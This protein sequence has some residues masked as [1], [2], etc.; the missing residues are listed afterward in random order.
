MKLK[1]NVLQEEIAELQSRLDTRNKQLNTILDK[2]PDT[3]VKKDSV[4]T[5]G[6]IVQ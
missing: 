6:I 5:Y 4:C 3:T 1:N 2:K